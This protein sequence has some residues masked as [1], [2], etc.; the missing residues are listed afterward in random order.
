MT[1]KPLLLFITCASIA[2]VVV[3]N[4]CRPSCDSIPTEGL[5]NVRIVNAVSNCNKLLVYIDGKLFDTCWFDVADE[6]STI[7][8]NHVFGYR[9][10]YLSDG[11]GLR[12]GLH[13]VAAM[14]AASRDTV[15]TWNGILYDHKQTLVFPGK[16]N[17]SALQTPQD[18]LNPSRR[19]RYLEDI[20]REPEA[21]TFAR[22]VDA[23]P[24]I[25]GESAG[26]LDVYFDT[27]ARVVNGI[28]KP[29]LRIHFDS[30]SHNNGLDNGGGL[31]SND[32]VEFPNTV[33]GLIIMP[34]NDVNQNDA[35]LNVPYS[36]SFKG[37]LFTVI[38]RGETVPSCNDPIASTILLEDGQLSPGSYIFDIKSFAIRLVN[39]SRD[40]NLSLLIKGSSD[41]G[42]RAGIPQGAGQEVLNLGAD[43][44][45]GYI[46]L[47]PIFDGNSQYWF[48]KSNNNSDTIFHFSYPVS[49]NQ[50]FTYI[51][52]DTIPHN[53]GTPGI[54]SMILAD[55]VCNPTNTANG[56]VR[57]V[58]T[59]PDYTATFTF[60]GK[61]F[62]LKQRGVVFADTAIGNYA[63]LLTGN[64][65][66]TTMNIPVGN[67]TPTTVFFMPADATHPLPYRITTQ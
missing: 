37:F 35:I 27:V 67:Q 52:I 46:P 66:S 14:D 13:H 22:F 21:S 62:S 15:A 40:P 9:T 24:D 60:A 5:A 38:I 12:S 3:L 49:A 7:N 43:S 33:P 29:D 63:I 16:M 11:T 50:R 59:S 64:S 47:N 36:S 44:V 58:N 65:T 31:D 41:A 45:G 57:F 51:A 34:V 30:I 48:S 23:V 39:A 4:G 8:P 32:Y 42:P 10:T 1:R 26:G 18:R 55:T 56:R 28:A 54:D 2:I 19:M 17:G 6:Y 20:T 61:P 25:D 53:T